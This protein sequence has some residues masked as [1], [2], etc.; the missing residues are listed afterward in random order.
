M[1]YFTSGTI[2][3]VQRSQNPT[4]PGHE[5]CGT[6]TKIPQLPDT[7]NLKQTDTICN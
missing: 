7:F 4:D 2:T 3:I 6:I 5:F 1:I